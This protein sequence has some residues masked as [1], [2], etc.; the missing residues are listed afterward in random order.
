M[1]ALVF[2]CV[3]GC[4]RCI[5]WY[6]IWGG[7]EWGAQRATSGLNAASESG[8][9]RMQLCPASSQLGEHHNDLC[10][11]HRHS[12]QHPSRATVQSGDV[13]SG[14]GAAAAGHT[15]PLAAITYNPR[16]AVFIYPLA[17]MA[18]TA[19]M[20]MHVQVCGVTA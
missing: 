19:S 5:P 14:E 4:C 2:C 16:V 17:F 15:S 18:A 3:V 20:F 7:F 10:A 6:L 1:L 12:P 9:R 8:T 11:A 13:G